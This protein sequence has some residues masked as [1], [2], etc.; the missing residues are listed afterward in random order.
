MPDVQMS[1]MYWTLRAGVKNSGCSVLTSTWPWTSCSLNNLFCIAASGRT[2]LVHLQA[3]DWHRI[4]F[5]HTLEGILV[6]SQGEKKVLCYQ[7][8]K[9]H[10]GFFEV[11]EGA[12]TPDCVQLSHPVTWYGWSPRFTKHFVHCADVPVNP[13]L[14]ISVAAWKRWIWT[15]RTVKSLHLFSSLGL[16]EQKPL[17]CQ[18][19]HSQ[20]GLPGDRTAD[21]RVGS[22]FSSSGMVIPFAREEANSRNE[23]KKILTSHVSDLSLFSYSQTKS[24]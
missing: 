12:V 17:K 16:R 11:G 13:K 9:T 18:R 19:S 24:V 7:L 5:Y 6:W 15:C 20:P 10:P 21:R 4:A 3:G 23:K 14:S 8:W 1:G 22:H 2:L